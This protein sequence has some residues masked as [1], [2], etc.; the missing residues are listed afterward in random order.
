[1][2]AWMLDRCSQRATALDGGIGLLPRPED[3]NTRGMSIEPQ[4]LRALLAV[5]APLW[6]KELA[7]TRAYLEQY[8]QRLPA[9]MIEQ[10]EKT[11]AALGR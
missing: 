7:E 10:L 1:M 4:T 5:D 9:Q 3:L 8:G 6:R 11:A 2:L